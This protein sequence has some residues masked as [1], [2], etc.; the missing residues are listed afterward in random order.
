ML[1]KL[2]ETRKKLKLK[3]S[4]TFVKGSVKNKVV[5]YNEKY[6]KINLKLLKK[7]A[8]YSFGFISTSFLLYYM[9][10]YN[11][12]PKKIFNGLLKREEVVEFKHTKMYFKTYTLTDYEKILDKTVKY[13]NNKNNKDNEKVF[14][15]QIDSYKSIVQYLVSSLQSL[16]YVLEKDDNT[17]NKHNKLNPTIKLI[18]FCI[19]E[20]LNLFNRFEFTTSIIFTKKLSEKKS[21][22]DDIICYESA[23][24]LLLHP[25]CH[26]E[27]IKTVLP[28]I[29]KKKLINFNFD[30]FKLGVNPWGKRHECLVFTSFFI[31]PNISKKYTRI[32]DNIFIELFYDYINNN[33]PP[34]DTKFDENDIRVTIK[35]S[36]TTSYDKI[37][38]DIQ[39]EMTKSELKTIGIQLDTCRFNEASAVYILSKLLESSSTLKNTFT[40][41]NITGFLG[42]HKERTVSVIFSDISSSSSSS[43]DNTKYY[44]ERKENDGPHSSIKFD[45]ENIDENCFI[46][47]DSYEKY[48][49]FL[50]IDTTHFLVF[51]PQKY[52]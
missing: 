25:Y 32:K 29:D 31:S 6:F 46:N 22:K 3:T 1:E 45:D 35:S 51:Y 30:T 49:N 2:K 16:L 27:V 24:I 33:M 8:K 37:I 26:S 52:L 21:K 23:S 4:R 11:F 41:E 12:N 18:M 42:T 5:R 7:I 20:L 39:K 38:D 9:I 36:A 47:I 19:R 34:K 43:N 10:H 13:A 40:T 44:S 15:I 14:N 50:E 17:D 48:I 28:T